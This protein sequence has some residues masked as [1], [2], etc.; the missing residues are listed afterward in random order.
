MRSLDHILQRFFRRLHIA[1]LW[2]LQ[3]SN[4]N[5]EPHYTL[6]C[7]ESS[8]VPTYFLFRCNIFS[9]KPCQCII[10]QIWGIAQVFR[11]DLTIGSVY[12]IV[13][14]L[15]IYKSIIHFKAVNE[16]FNTWFI[17]Q[18]TEDVDENICGVKKGHPRNAVLPIPHISHFFLHNHN[19]RPENCTLESA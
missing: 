19:L 13:I 15:M 3:S 7:R 16:C 9:Q 6:F 11:K 18:H 4:K 8:F 1:G 10:W 2:D 17:F 5:Q 12:I 14:L